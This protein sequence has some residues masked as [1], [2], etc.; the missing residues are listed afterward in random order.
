MKTIELTAGVYWVGVYDHEL[1]VFDEL[2]PTQSGT[3]YNSY[4]VK[5]GGKTVL[6]DT[7][8]EHFFTEF[9]SRVN[10]VCAVDDIDI[11]ISNHTEHDHSGSIA[12]LLEMNPKIEVYCTKA[13]EKFLQQQMNRSFNSHSIK[14]GETLDLGGRTLQFIVAPYLHWP[15]TMFTYLQEDQL[16]FSCD[17]FGAHYCPQEG[18][19]FCDE[20]N[21]DVQADLKL[22]FDTIV[23]PFKKNVREAIAKLADIPVKM[24]CPSHGPVRRQDIEQTVQDYQLWSQQPQPTQGRRVLLLEHSPHGT[25]RKMGDRVTHALQARGCTVIRL[26]AIELDDQQF[27]HELERCDALMIGVATINRDAGPPVWKA[28][29]LLSTVTVKNKLAA[30]YG[31]Y[32]WSGEAVK[33]IQGRLLGLRYKLAGEGVRWQFTPTQDDIDHCLQ[34][35]NDL[36]DLLHAS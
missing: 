36:A 26:S 17:A 19:I 2:Y 31:A 30:V 20:I 6:V 5:G 16:L 11:I 34:L 23:R 14:D 25:V 28:L 1:R 32:G 10:S 9:L 8:E 27:Q 33:L 18:Q 15:D 12:R 7:A 4:L 3:T 35:A 21:G 24:I 13:A 29:A 22:Y